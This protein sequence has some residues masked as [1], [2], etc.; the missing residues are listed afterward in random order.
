MIPKYEVVLTD[1]F[2]IV[3]NGSLFNRGNLARRALQV[4]FQF[5]SSKV[6][7]LSQ[8][9]LS[10]NYPVNGTNA[11]DAPNCTFNSSNNNISEFTHCDPALANDKELGLFVRM[12]VWDKMPDQLYWQGLYRSQIINGVQYY[13]AELVDL[14][15]R[16]LTYNVSRPPNPNYINFT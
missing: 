10:A 13:D 12:A 16:I 1:T 7:T 11:I 15:N 14:G 6:L 9:D 8:K 5:V 3:R 2:L 4:A